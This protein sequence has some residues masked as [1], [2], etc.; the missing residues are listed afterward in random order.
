MNL[1]RQYYYCFFV[2]ASLPFSTIA[3]PPD[4]GTLL[5]DVKPPPALPATHAGALPE[6]TA[7]PAA[8]L[9]DQVGIAIRGFRIVGAVAV[10][11]PELQ[12]LLAD[13]IGK[14]LTLAGIDGH[15]RRITARYR[16][17]G[18][19]LARAYLPAQEIKDGIVEIAVLEG[20]LGRLGIDN[21]SPL[22]DDRV[23][24]SLA[25]LRAGEAVRG[26][27]LERGL[28]L[29]SDLPGVEVVSTLKPGASVG[30]TDLDV[31]LTGKSPYAGGIEADNFGNRYTG[32]WRPGGYFTA[33]NLAGLADTLAVRALAAEGLSYGRIAWQLPVGTAG[34]QAGIAW[35]DMHYRLGKDFA[36][37]DAHGTA[38]IG[39]LYLLHPFVRGRANNIS[40]QL[41]YDRKRLA[42]DVDSTSSRGRKTIDA[43]IAGISGTG[44]DGLG[45]GGLTQWSL[46]WTAGRLALDD[47]NRALDAAGHRSAGHFGKLN[48]AAERL[49]RLDGAIDLHV[50][51]TA[52]AAAK[53]LDSAE[54]MSLGGAQGVRAY[55][56]GEA[57][58]DDAWLA[59]LELRRGFGDAWQASLFYDRA[60]GWS[61]HAPIAAD[62][63]NDRRLAGYGFGLAYDAGSFTAR[64]SVAWRDGPRPDSDVDR[65]PRVWF[66]AQRRF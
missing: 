47:D 21:R 54:K 16:D 9:D 63:D 45:G 53:N 37:L 55:P 11:A 10:P 24:A 60:R 49:Q 31:R 33:G 8:R 41:N 51:F 7:K 15:A 57:P 64:L 61:N 59:S 1:N 39:S 14:E 36:D 26:D 23:A 50:R 27:V 29:L 17:A 12:A 2:L 6:E 19:P 25:G 65:G 62:G 48:L 43:L 18:Y 3:A 52:Q 22:P 35:S 5:Q 38:R 56:Q 66:Q 40:G 20:R 32:E 30:T 44:T 28:L 13:A 58:A 4:A 34:T 42:D 46:A